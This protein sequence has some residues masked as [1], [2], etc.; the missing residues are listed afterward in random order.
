MK[1]TAFVLAGFSAIAF[2]IAGC[3][4]PAEVPA[5]ARA[6][7]SMPADPT[8]STMEPTSSNTPAVLGTIQGVG[9]VTVVDAAAGTVTL[10]HEAI[11]AINWPAM[12]MQFKAEDPSIL[13]GIAKGDHVVFGLKNAEDTGT[14]TMITKQ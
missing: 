6:A 1:K 14:V 5:P 12:S 11:N 13:K 10:D 9:I 3:S 2:G 7:E 8:G 4:K